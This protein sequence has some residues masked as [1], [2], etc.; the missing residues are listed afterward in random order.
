MP[1]ILTTDDLLTELGGIASRSDARAMVSRAARVAGVA[2]GRPLEMR[3]LLM[4]CDALAAEGGAIQ[5]LA[6][7]IASR[8][9]RA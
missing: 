8:A 2:A 1:F 6:E 4:V 5:R 3:E 7:S 9:L